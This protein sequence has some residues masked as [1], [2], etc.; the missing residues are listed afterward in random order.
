MCFYFVNLKNASKTCFLFSKLENSS[1]TCFF[2]FVNLK[3]ATNT[4]FYFVNL[5]YD[6]SINL[7]CLEK[8][9]LKLLNRNLVQQTEQK[10][11]F[12][13][14]RYKRKTSFSPTKLS[15]TPHH[16]TTKQ[17]FFTHFG[18]FQRQKSTFPN[19]EKV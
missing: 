16:I 17:L 18:R 6:V 3:H 8:E 10:Q 7:Q 14:E 9:K 12:S 19:Q 4:I 15:P 11:H 1:E 13:I 5:K 2:H